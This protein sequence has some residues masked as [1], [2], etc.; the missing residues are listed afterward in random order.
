MRSDRRQKE[1]Q[2]VLSLTGLDEVV[3]PVERELGVSER[4][5]VTRE[6]LDSFAR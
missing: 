5:L 3:A 1:H 2:A 6:N 4:Q